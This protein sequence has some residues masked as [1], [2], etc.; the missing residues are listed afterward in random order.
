VTDIG[1]E[2]SFHWENDEVRVDIPF[3]AAGIGTTIVLRSK[4]TGRIMLLDVGD[5]AVRDLLALSRSANWIGDLDL[6]A[7]SH[8]HFDH[9]GGLHTLLSFMRMLQRKDSL[10]ILIPKGSSESIGIIKGYRELY[11]DSHP[12]PTWYHELTDGSE[13]DTDFF[14]VQ[15]IAVEHYSLESDPPEALIP[16]LGY[17]VKIGSTT[18]AYTGDTRLCEGAGRI[19]SGADL[20]IIEATRREPPEDGYRVHLTVDEA[21]SLGEKAKECMLIHRIPQL[22]KWKPPPAV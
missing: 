11:H 9:I 16:A 12:Y 7:I 8:G 20:A 4:F 14:K 1:N 2:Y 19:V 15:A 10:S 13:F 18:I 22:P 3:S 17:R 21:K 6:I 5:G